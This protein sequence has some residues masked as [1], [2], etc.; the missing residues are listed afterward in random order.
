MG[1]RVDL[2]RNRFVFDGPFAAAETEHL[3]EWYVEYLRA[4]MAEQAAH[5]SIANPDNAPLD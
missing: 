4:W 5:P 1:L 2:K 3:P